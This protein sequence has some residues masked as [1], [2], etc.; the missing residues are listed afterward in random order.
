LKANLELPREMALAIVEV[1]E[2]FE[3]EIEAL[4]KTLALAKTL[5][6]EY[7]PTLDERLSA[8]RHDPDLLSATKQK[9]NAT[10]DMI[11]AEEQD[12]LAQKEIDRLIVR[13]KPTTLLN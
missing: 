7:A 3:I 11:Y 10:R 2:R 1:V 12:V 6:P 5:C 4:R 13:L 8:V 9:Y